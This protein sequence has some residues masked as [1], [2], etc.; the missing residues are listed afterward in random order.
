MDLKQNKKSKKKEAKKLLFFS[1]KFSW[2]HKRK[3]ISNEENQ[4][5]GKL[6]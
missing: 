6:L 4:T 1:P 5:S 2:N 3:M